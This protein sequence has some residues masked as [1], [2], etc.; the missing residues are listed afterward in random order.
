MEG[1]N[2]LYLHGIQGRLV[3]RERMER[4]KHLALWVN[5]PEKEGNEGPLTDRYHPVSAVSQ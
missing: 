3:R 2:R 1:I 5:N 4:R